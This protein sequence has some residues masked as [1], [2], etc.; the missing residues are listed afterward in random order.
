[1]T[2]ADKKW[3]NRQTRHVKIRQG[4][5]SKDRDYYKAKTKTKAEIKTETKT[6]TKTK[7][8]KD[9]KTMPETKEKRKR[10]K[11]KDKRHKT[12]SKRQRQKTK[13]T[14][15]RL[16]TKHKKT[17][18][19]RPGPL[20]SMRWWW[21]GTFPAPPCP[22]SEEKTDDKGENDEILL[23]CSYALGKTTGRRQRPKTKGQRPKTKDQRPKTKD[24]RLKTK[25]QGKVVN[26]ANLQGDIS[27]WIPETNVL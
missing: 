6:T 26:S 7:K 16:K 25:D 23:E 24:Q 17:S 8:D 3:I 14:T 1:M 5:C 2:S 4:E 13:T 11:D 9:Q 19:S 22:T 15:K 18:N 20:W 12:K 21:C 27:W 10:T